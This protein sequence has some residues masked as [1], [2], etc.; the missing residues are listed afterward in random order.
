MRRRR[1]DS[2]PAASA[3]A[4]ATVSTEGQAPIC[5]A[6]TCESTNAAVPT[7]PSTSAV[8]LPSRRSHSRMHHRPPAASTTPPSGRDPVEA[9]TA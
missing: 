6:S 9:A 3:V 5:G 8:R 7:E 2:S 4:P 1:S